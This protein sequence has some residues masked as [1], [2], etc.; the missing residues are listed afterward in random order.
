MKELSPVI[1]PI[2]QQYAD[3]N[4]K[5][6]FSHFLRFFTNFELFPELIS[7]NQMKII[8]FTLN[9][10]SRNFNLNTTNNNL[11]FNTEYKNTQIKAERLE[12]N[13]FLEALAITAMIFNYKN[14]ISD[15]DRLIYLCFQ[16]HNAKPIRD[17]KLKGIIASQA[18]KNLEKFL[19]E[20]IKTYKNKNK[21]EEENDDDKEN[22]EPI[23]YING[24]KLI[25]DKEI[26]E[27]LDL[28]FDFDDDKKTE[29]IYNSFF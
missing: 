2:Y 6:S 10:S 15:I 28:Q 23:K 12:Y 8:F 3:V 19:K 14:I 13:T 24:E 4:N 27:Q 7:L 29:N 17:D 18:N 25:T 16:I 1:F 22:K 20:F 11:S 5:M 9:E 21:K 26:K